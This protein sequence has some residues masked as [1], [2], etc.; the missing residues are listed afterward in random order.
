MK[1]CS[2]A[3]MRS[4]THLVLQMWKKKKNKKTN[5]GWWIIIITRILWPPAACR[6]FSGR[7]ALV[8]L[9]AATLA[10]DQH[11]TWRSCCFQIFQPAGEIANKDGWFWQVAAASKKK[12]KK[13][14]TQASSQR[15]R[16]KLRSYD[17]RLPTVG[18]NRRGENKLCHSSCCQR[19]CF[20]FPASRCWS[21]A[22]VISNLCPR[23]M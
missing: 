20:E 17:N 11:L 10:G 1:S 5:M 12:K 3:E 2:A 14:N 23:L 19:R 7:L 13:V 9:L 18:L 21:L 15:T 4:P 8:W 22:A 6:E 16:S